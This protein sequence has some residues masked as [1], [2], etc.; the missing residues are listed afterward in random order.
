MADVPSFYHARA[1]EERQRAS[2]ATLENVRERCLRSEAAW[3]A[4][5]VRAE[6][7]ATARKERE[8]APAGVEQPVLAVAG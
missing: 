4:M 6:R 3:L 7:T 5:A 2:E 1:A 8:R